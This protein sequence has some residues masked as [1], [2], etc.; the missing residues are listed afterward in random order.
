MIPSLNEM[1]DILGNICSPKI[2]IQRHQKIL[3]FG[4]WNP[5]NREQHLKNYPRQVL[6]RYNCIH[7]IRKYIETR[8]LKCVIFL[9]I[10]VNT[11]TSKCANTLKIT[12]ISRISMRKS[13]KIDLHLWVQIK[14]S[15]M[16][17]STKDCALN[18][19]F[20]IIFQC[21]SPYVKQA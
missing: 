4:F 15:E 2:D 16:H 9:K 14:I 20:Y 6:M 18:C 11:G 21:S 7:P 17:Y 10:K 5:Q 3:V 12:V 13:Y 19:A 1:C 8:C